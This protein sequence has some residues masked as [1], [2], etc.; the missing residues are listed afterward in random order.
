MNKDAA[1]LPTQ[2][3]KRGRDL[4]VDL[5]GSALWG[6]F[7]AAYLSL[8]LRG[9]DYLDVGLF[10]FYLLAACF[11]V[12]RRPAQRKVAWWENVLAWLCVFIPIAGLRPAAG[13]WEISGLVFQ[14]LGLLGLVAALSSLKHSF[15][16]A[17]ADRGLVTTGLY[18]Y[19]RHPIY[20]SELVF[21][22]GYLI[23]NP[24]WRNLGVLLLMV[25]TQVARIL[26]EE[27]I[28]SGYALYADQVRWRCLPGI[29]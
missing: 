11:M 2:A 7:G 4:V 6:F 22:A 19:V 8:A 9:G 18:R 12:I 13:G 15:G 3:L 28:I 10:L 29:W 23:S 17:P 16:I 26:R 20:A 24:S 1:P 21:N 14:S 25:A 5:A 27:K